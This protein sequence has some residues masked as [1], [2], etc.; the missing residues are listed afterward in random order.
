VN[1]TMNMSDA[2]L[3]KYH[4][5]IHTVTHS[6]NTNH[7]KYCKFHKEALQNEHKQF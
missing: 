6:L 7:D 5:R 1:V 2:E 4:I 3:S